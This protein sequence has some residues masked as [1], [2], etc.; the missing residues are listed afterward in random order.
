MSFVK[1]KI[2]CGLLLLLVSFG[3]CGCSGAEEE[4]QET[5][6][7]EEE[8]VYNGVN[9]VPLGGLSVFCDDVIYYVGEGEN[10][11]ERICSMTDDG[12]NDTVLYTP[13]SALDQISFLNT[14]GTSLYFLETIIDP[15]W[16]GVTEKRIRKQD[17]ASG[18]VETL[19]NPSMV[20]CCL[21]YHDGALYYTEGRDMV[22]EDPYWME[23]NYGGDYRLMR[24]SVDG[25]KAEKLTDFPSAIFIIYGDRIWCGPDSWLSSI[26]SYDLNGGDKREIYTSEEHGVELLTVYGGRIY[27]CEYFFEAGHKIYSI[28]L[29]GKDSREL[30]SVIGSDCNV[31]DGAFYFMAHTEE[32]IVS[33]SDLSVVTGQ[34]GNVS[35]SDLATEESMDNSP[36]ATGSDLVVEGADSVRI[37]PGSTD[38]F[39]YDRTDSGDL[40][41]RFHKESGDESLGSFSGSWRFYSALDRKN[42]RILYKEQMTE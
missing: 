18:T 5:P 40:K 28:D 4:S 17:L 26:I 20:T 37:I 30:A 31:I 3:L 21:T 41:L 14:D 27:F 15:Q 39:C 29:E 10:G 22:E 1:G 36:P 25:G 13:E 9:N 6:A 35:D 23:E 32:T 24:L 2:W 16:L 8:F 19:E 11:G 7:A 34:S 38:L 42:G 33:D 12:E